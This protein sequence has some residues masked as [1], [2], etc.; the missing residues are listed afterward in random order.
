MGKLIDADLLKMWL[1]MRE[2]EDDN[3]ITARSVKT[4]IDIQPEA[5]I[6][7]GDCKYRGEKL[8][9]AASPICNLRPWLYIPI[10]DDH[11]CSAGERR[12]DE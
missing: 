9:D 6:R 5:V 10:A 11:F 7:C 1:N 3:F 2:N 12:A 8:S 4:F